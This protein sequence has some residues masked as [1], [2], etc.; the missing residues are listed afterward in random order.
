MATAGTSI[1]RERPWLSTSRYLT[2]SRSVTIECAQTV[3]T[4]VYSVCGRGKLAASS[5]CDHPGYERSA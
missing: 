4:D 3:G 1:H 2:L 5:D